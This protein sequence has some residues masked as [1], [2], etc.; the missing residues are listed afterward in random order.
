MVKTCEICGK[1]FETGYSFKK[2]CSK[3][4]RRLSLNARQ[5]LKRQRAAKVEI[6]TCQNC[7]KQFETAN[8]QKVYCSPK[9][10][11]QYCYRKKTVTKVE[12]PVEKIKKPV[13]EPIKKICPICGVEFLTRNKGQK[14]CSKN[15]T[16]QASWQDKTFKKI[17]VQCG[18]EFN[19]LS[20]AAKKCPSCR[21]QR[22]KKKNLNKKVKFNPVKYIRRCQYCGRE[23]ATYH[24]S[25]I[26][27]SPECTQLAQV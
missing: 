20:N 24:A 9:C 15:C 16:S 22:E 17:C 4:C 3:K 13:A 10:V 5:N 21:F 2:Y 8:K 19:S 11:H 26:C 6:H 7:G 23:F 1:E 12:K 14:Y 18:K 27:C 25:R